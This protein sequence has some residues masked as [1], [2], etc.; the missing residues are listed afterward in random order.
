METQIKFN[1]TVSVCTPKIQ[2]V[3]VYWIEEEERNSK[4][5]LDSANKPLKT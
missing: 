5:E 1:K 4:T 2:L 3:K